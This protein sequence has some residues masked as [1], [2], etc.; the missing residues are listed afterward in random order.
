M[1]DEIFTPPTAPKDSCFSEENF[2]Q[3]VFDVDTFLQE[4]KKNVSLEKMRDDLGIYLK[5][6]RSAMIELINKDYADFVNLSSNLI[7]L[8]KAIENL[9]TPLGQL[10]EEVMQVRQYLE[11]AISEVTANLDEHRNIRG[12]KQSL[13]SLIRIHKSI[14]KLSSILSAGNTAE[15]P[16]K[17]DILERAATE[18][19]Q[20]KFHTSRCSADFTTAQNEKSAELDKLLTEHLNNIFLNYVKEKDSTFLTRCLRIYVT[21]DKIFEAEDVIR[22]QLVKPKIEK[23]INEANL[24]SEPLGI[25]GIYLKLEA[26]LDEDFKQLLDITL[27]PER[28]SVKG[29]N[30]LVNSFWT[31]VEDRTEEYLSCI[32]APGNPQL[33][34]QRYTETLGFLSRIEKRCDSL[35]VVKTLK[36]HVQYKR[37]LK[38]WNLAVYYQI[39]FQEIAGSAESV[40]CANISPACIKKRK[41]EIDR[42]SFSLYSTSTVWDC[43]LRTWSDH[44]FLSQLLHRFW[45]LNLQICSRYNEWCKGSLNQKWQVITVNEIS[46]VTETEN[47]TRLEFLVCLYTDVDIFI[48]LLQSIFQLA[49]QKVKNLNEKS[50]KLLEDCLGETRKNLS[51]TLPLITQ[52]IVKELLSQSAFHLKQISDIPRLFRRTNRE[53]PTKPCAYVKNALSFL[54][55]FYDDYFPIIPQ[56]TNLW[57]LQTLSSLTEQYISSVTD[58]LTSVQKTEESLRKLKKIRDKSSGVSSSETQGVSDDEKIRIQLSIDVSNFVSLIKS[59]KVSEAEVPRLH[60]L[61]QIVEAAVKNRNEAK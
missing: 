60:D 25:Q 53:I 58:V 42:D 49:N 26:I 46:T 34:H 45:K 14:S 8:D 35:E 9:E 31:E 12:R 57:L 47:P 10:R 5:I 3:K 2:I 18:F 29:F 52:E 21:L 20:L 28:T 15:Q 37:F 19:N 13:H 59:L 61:T 41:N 27:Y 50:C 36:N 4:H 7:G 43:I 30:F 51:E 55:A 6:L 39:R 33:F 40:L 48:R 54:S 44:V 56:E 38:K 17:P 16:I 23:I 1:S 11:D 22:K 32:F 24:Q